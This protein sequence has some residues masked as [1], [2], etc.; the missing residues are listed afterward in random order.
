MNSKVKYE[1]MHSKKNLIDL[2][3]SEE[4]NEPE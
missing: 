3:Q 2:S 1:I 4:D